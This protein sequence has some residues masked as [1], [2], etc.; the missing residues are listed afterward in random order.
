[1]NHKAKKKKKKKKIILHGGATRTTVQP[2]HKRSS[3]GASTRLKEPVPHV[4][5]AQR[6]QVGIEVAGVS[7]DA[8]RRFLFGRQRSDR[9]LPI[10]ETVVVVGRTQ[11]PESS[12]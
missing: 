4:H 3:R 11:M 10:V 6:V 9:R 1:M 5:S 8:F 7:C 2:K 12:T